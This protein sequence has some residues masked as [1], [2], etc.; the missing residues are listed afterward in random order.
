M[1]STINKD[2]LDKVV[3]NNAVIIS[4][5]F[6]PHPF[7]ANSLALQAIEESDP[8]PYIA[9]LFNNMAKKGYD[10]SMSVSM[11]LYVGVEA[12]GKNNFE[13][14]KQS[15]KYVMLEIAKYGATSIGGRVDYPTDLS[16]EAD[17]AR[18]GQSPIR[19]GFLIT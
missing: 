4:D 18:A 14:F 2:W 17:L 12:I 11:R 6:I 9:D 1:G 13:A 16:A 19:Y 7:T 3:P 15:L 10:P 8:D 5:D